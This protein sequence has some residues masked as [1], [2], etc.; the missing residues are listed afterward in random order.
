[1]DNQKNKG[2]K[3]PLIRGQI[4]EQDAKLKEMFSAA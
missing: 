3:E 4:P 1:M 2:N